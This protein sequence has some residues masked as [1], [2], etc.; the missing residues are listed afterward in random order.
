MCTLIIVPVKKGWYVLRTYDAVKKEDKTLFKTKYGLIV[1]TALPD[2]YEPEKGGKRFVTKLEP[3][4]GAGF[5]VNQENLWAA[6]TDLYKSRQKSGKKRKGK[7]GYVGKLTLDILSKFSNNQE[8][9][10]YVEEEI[11]QKAYKAFNIAFG[12][13]DGNLDIGLIKR[14]GEIMW[15]NIDKS[16][17]YYVVVNYYDKLADDEDDSWLKKDSLLRK[18]RAK[19][20]LDSLE[21]I[22]LDSLCE[23]FKDHKNPG[24]SEPETFESTICRHSTEERLFETLYATAMF[25]SYGGFSNNKFRFVNGKPCKNEFVD[26]SSLLF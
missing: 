8:V 25:V 10:R 14:T 16:R 21:E 6:V 24:G 4:M 19:E 2:V 20:L 3:T 18:K 15:R 23:I 7:K 17:K 9:K 26:L 22:T 5:G 11:K 13:I 1:N 12:D